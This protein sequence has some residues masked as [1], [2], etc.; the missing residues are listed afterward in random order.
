VVIGVDLNEQNETKEEAKGAVR[1]SAQRSNM[2]EEEEI[3]VTFEGVGL[4][5]GVT[6]E[7][8]KIKAKE[9]EAKATIT[10]PKGTTVGLVTPN[11]KLLDIGRPVFV[12]GAAGDLKTET[13]FKLMIEAKR[14]KDQ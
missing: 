1:V 2:K 6:I 9:N 8:T 7:N 4:P 14:T 13:Q 10:V 12:R 5:N 3:A 11:L